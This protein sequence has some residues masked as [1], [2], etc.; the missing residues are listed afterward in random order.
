MQGGRTESG[1]QFTACQDC[2]RNDSRI[3]DIIWQDRIACRVV[4]V[5]AIIIEITT[6]AGKSTAHGSLADTPTIRGGNGY[7]GNGVR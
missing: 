2:E 7:R 5:V 1:W 3:L 6:E 4:A